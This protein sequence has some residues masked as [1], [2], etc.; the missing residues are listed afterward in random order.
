MKQ[1]YITV[2][3]MHTTTWVNVYHDMTACVSR[4]KS[5]C[6]TAWVNAYPT[7]FSVCYDMKWFIPKIVYTWHEFFIPRHDL[8]YIT[9]W[10]SVHY[11]WV[12]VYYYRSW[13][14][15]IE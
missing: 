4:L 1:R 5:K 15:T 11:A 12:K 7:W 8:I 9:N 2:Y 13:Y 10:A 3:L 6:T 14:T